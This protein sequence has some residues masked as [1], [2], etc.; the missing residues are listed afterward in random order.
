M[1]ILVSGLGVSAASETV[2][3]NA[4]ILAPIDNAARVTL[5][6]NTRPEATA[7]NDRGQVDD[8]QPLEDMQLLL[9]RSPARQ[10]ALDA[11]VASLSDKSSPN[12]RKWIAPT[13]IGENYGVALSDLDQVVDWLKSSG[14]I[15]NVV[16]PNRVLIDFS[17]TAAQV[18]EAFGTEIHSYEV[19]GARHIANA[20]D[21]TIP[22][23]LA[24]VVAG[25]VS[26]HDFMPH[27]L[28]KPRPDYTFTNS[29][30]TYYAVTP[31][32]LATVYNLNPLFAAGYTGKGQSIAVI[33]DTNVYTAADWTAF[34]KEFGLSGYSFGSFTQVHPLPPSGNN[35]C[36]NPGVVVGN[37]AEAILDAEYA[38]A[39][40]PNAAIELYSCTDTSTTF[41]GLI[42]LE[43]LLNSSARP[44]AAVS[45]SYGEC[46]AENG[47]AANAIYYAT[48]EQAVAEGVSVFVSAGD[49]GAASCDADQTTATHGIGVSAFASTPYN[50]AVGGTDFGDTYAGIDSTYWNPDNTKTFASAVSYIPEIPWND[51]CASELISTY[52]GFATTFGSTGFCN[53]AT[54]TADFLSTAAGSGGPSGCATGTPSISGVVGG[55]CKGYPKPSWQS[56]VGVP[57]DG[58]LDIP[59]ISLFAANGV[60]GHYYVFC[61]SD[62]AKD[63]GGAPCTGAPSGWSGAGGTSFASPILAGIQALVTE[64]WGRQGNPNPVYYAIAASEYGAAGRST[65]NSTLG[66]AIGS[67][68][69]FH[70]VTLGDIDVNCAA[71]VSGKGSKSASTPY[72]C[73]LDGTANGALSTSSK[74]YS[75]AYKTATG[76][77][78][79]TGIGSVNAYNLVISADW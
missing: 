17:G 25:I 68:C 31:P 10:A 19:D 61:Y 28:R 34:R 37:D 65:C 33:E 73:Y 53:S 62:P 3:P 74:S 27:P 8:S 26:L 39:A 30:S 22:A 42:A 16:Y 66:N 49:E 46:E 2:A 43:N 36:L 57:E 32:D 54:G 70:D 77:D 18:R 4:R 23:A 64:K 58:V 12:Y 48:Y 47:A 15:V 6:G 78:F 63:Q 38:S 76:W 50:V 41:G 52:V 7:A 40:A 60:W 9:S 44:P 71:L 72:N 14:F 56:L 69:V 11:Y 5:A 21:P 51:S 67:A 45:I 24:P 35:N 59:D 79:A 55:T 20:S 75:P 1:T 29:G 13:L